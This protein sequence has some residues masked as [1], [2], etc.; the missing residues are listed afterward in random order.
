MV[1]YNSDDSDHSYKIT[2]DK[3]KEKN[4]KLK[5]FLKKYQKLYKKLYKL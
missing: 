5:K 3:D 1:E 2:N 4:F